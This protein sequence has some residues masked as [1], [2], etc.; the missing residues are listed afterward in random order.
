MIVDAATVFVVDDDPS[1]RKSLERLLGHR[2]Y[3]T[4]SFDNARAFLSSPRDASPSCAVIDLRL[5]EMDGLE[6]QQRLMQLQ[7]SIPVIFISGYGDV[8]AS[9]QAMKQG[10]TDFLTKPVHDED[11]LR[12]VEQALDRDRLNRVEFAEMDAL[13]KRVSLLTPRE[14][15][16]FCEIVAGKLNKQIAAALGIA[17]KTVKVHRHRV[18]EKTGARSVAD[19]VRLAGRLFNRETSGGTV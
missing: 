19:L 4:A 9:V 18:M 16:V 11:L 1:V 2:G 15:Q 13:R 8:P 6:L 12:A 10:A 17:E 7:Q 3:R 5:P 14:Y